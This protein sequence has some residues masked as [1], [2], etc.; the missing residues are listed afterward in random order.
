MEGFTPLNGSANNSMPVGG[1]RHRSGKLKL[2]TRKQARKLLKRLGRKMRGGAPDAPG[3][4][5]A[6]KSD[7]AM[8]GRRRTRKHRGKHHKTRGLLPSLG[9]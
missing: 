2:V 3:A 6:E 9:L 7:A 1:R 8:G 5:V 4:V